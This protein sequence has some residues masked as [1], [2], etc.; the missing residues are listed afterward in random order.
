MILVTWKCS[1]CHKKE[2]LWGALLRL[3]SKKAASA[4]NS[5]L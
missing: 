3:T 5:A 2:K 4:V 1:G